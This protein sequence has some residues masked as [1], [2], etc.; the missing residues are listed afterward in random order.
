MGATLARIEKGLP[1]ATSDRLFKSLLD[2][3]VASI[4]FVGYSGSDFFDVDPFLA[5]LPPGAM[6]GREV[7]WI[8][9]RRDETGLGD[10]EGHVNPQ[11]FHSLRRH[12]ETIGARGDAARTTLL[13]GPWVFPFSRAS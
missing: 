8:S 12:F 13:A 5:G 11:D 4:V 10:C 2:P 3:A 7:L 6:E 1:A 9:H